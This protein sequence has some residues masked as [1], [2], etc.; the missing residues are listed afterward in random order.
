MKGFVI[1]TDAAHMPATTL[2]NPICYEDLI[3][4]GDPEF[5][6]PDFDENTACGMC[7]TSG[8]DGASKGRA[9]LAPLQCAAWPH[10]RA[11]RCH[12]DFEP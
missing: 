5:A 2:R 11:G 7:Y 9:L 1:M 10:V 3:A 8:H 4:E 6:W 12:G